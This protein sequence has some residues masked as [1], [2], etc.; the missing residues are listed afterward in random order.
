MTTVAER[1]ADA[2]RRSGARAGR[3]RA[4]E[5][6]RR[7]TSRD[8]G[9]WCLMP[10]ERIVRVVG[11]ADGAAHLSG[12]RRCASTWCCPV[13]TPTIR[14]QRAAE[15][16]Q[17]V[18][19]H[20]AGGGQA[21]LVT[22]TFSHQKGDDLAQLLDVGQAAWSKTWKISDAVKRSN[23]Y[24]GQVRAW[25]FTHSERNG[26]HPHIHA[27]VLCGPGDA[28]GW[29][30]SMAHRWS[31]K[32]AGE[33]A[34]TDV[35]SARSPGWDVRRIND[36]AGMSDYLCKVQ[37]GWGAGLELARA[38]IKRGS[39]A[40]VTPAV[41]MERAIDGD[42]R[43]LV[44]IREFERATAGRRAVVW[45]RG[46]KALLGVEEVDDETAAVTEPAGA[47]T[48][49]V[50]VPGRAWRRLLYLGEAAELVASVGLLAAGLDP[51]AVSWRWPNGWLMAW[52][53]SSA[54][55]A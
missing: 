18:S 11:T 31:D 12:I 44:L 6:W 24:V 37:G 4:L 28:A 29:L 26:W 10:L 38:D 22:A 21:F 3:Y 48:V 19:A 9:R 50:A 1:T 20:L 54:W 42:P 23:S 49:E 32:I 15:I 45:G 53:Q 52:R 5:F 17:G 46:L 8:G 41:L 13:C 35:T 33:G 27:I 55:A 51:G 25:D 39:R 7:W 34:L 43:A 14:E 2:N 36:S 40:G 30:W 16:D 47:I